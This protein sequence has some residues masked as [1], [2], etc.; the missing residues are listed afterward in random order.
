MPKLVSTATGNVNL[1]RTM[2]H[3]L[4]LDVPKAYSSLFHH[5][6]D[7]LPKADQVVC[8]ENSLDLKENCDCE[9]TGGNSLVLVCSPET[10]RLGYTK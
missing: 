10:P 7:G 5:V 2:T 3:I 8:H 6:T 4:S 9:T 1:D